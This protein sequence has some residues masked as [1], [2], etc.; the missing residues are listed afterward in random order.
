MSSEQVETFPWMSSDYFTSILT[1]YEG[2]DDLQLRE[3]NVSSGTNKG[4]NFASAIFR[5]KLNYLLHGE[6]KEITVIIKTSS[7]TSAI[8]EM[9]ED[10]GTFEGEAHVYSNILDECKKLFPNFKLAPR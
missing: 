5:V 6:A 7:A 8:S 1:K 10:L 3:F 9:L 2:H 4:E